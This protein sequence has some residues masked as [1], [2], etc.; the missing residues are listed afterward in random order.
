MVRSDYSYI[1]WEKFIKVL[2]NFWNVDI[3]SQRWSH[4]KVKFN[5]KVT[6]IIP[7]HKQ[8]AYGT[9]HSILKQLQINESDFIRK[10]KNK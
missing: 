8:L 3:V 6:T 5:N 9:F 1:S 7:N 4:I 2:K 10:I